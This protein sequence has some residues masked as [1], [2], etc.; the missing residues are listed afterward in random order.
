M[1][2]LRPSASA[3]WFNCPAQP[4]MASRV[5]QE[6]PGDPAREGTCAAWVAEMVLTGQRERCIAM[7]G[8]SHENGWLVEADMASMVQGYVDN[9]RSHGDG[10]VVAEK[11][12]KLNAMIQG[13]PDGFAVADGNTLFV[14]D[15]KYGYGVVEPYRN[16]QVGCYMGALLNDHPHIARVVI[17]IYQPRAWHPL[18]HY[19]TWEISRAE[20]EAFVA[21]IEIAG[22]ACQDTNAAAQAG[23]HCDYCPAAAT[24]SALAGAV[25]QSHDLLAAQHQRHM[26][27][28]EARRELRFLDDAEAMLKARKNAVTAEVTARIGRGETFRGWHLQQAVGHRRWKDGITPE[29]IETMTGVDVVKRDTVTPAQAEA[30]GIPH[31]VVEVMTEKPTLAPKLKPVPKNYYNKLFDNPS[32]KG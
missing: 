21:E 18:G 13:T 19:R 5:P 28:E 24:C 12:V 6:E 31:E 32:N 10:P 2:Q 20:A 9:L 27:A 17:G 1:I 4:L 25:Y 11:H 30:L 23:A 15:L 26:T 14:D 8:E 3:M 22:A 7:I 29:M 16:T